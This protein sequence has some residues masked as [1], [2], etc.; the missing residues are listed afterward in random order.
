MPQEPESR[1]VPRWLVWLVIVLG[2][3]ILILLPAV[4]M[5]LAKVRGASA[6]QDEATVREAMARYAAA[7]VEYR[8]DHAQPDGGST[9]AAELPML[10]GLAPDGMIAAWGPGGT[11]W[12][13][14]LFREAKS[15]DGVP[16]E[17]ADDFALSAVPARYGQPSRLSFIVVT[18][19]TVRDEDRGAGAGFV[20]D[21][22]C[23][24]AGADARR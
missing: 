16:I 14:Y 2:L 9:Y 11:P 19:G 5:T 24:R 8:R 20:E 21:C 1:S 13:G 4:L 15:I 10:R 6:A 18:G 22:R 7:Q 12:R 23:A 3:A 17:W